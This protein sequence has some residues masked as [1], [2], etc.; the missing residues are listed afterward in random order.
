WKFK[1][2]IQKCVD[3]GDSCSLFETLRSQTKD[4]LRTDDAIFLLTKKADILNG[5]TE[6]YSLLFS[7]KTIVSEESLTAT[8][9][10]TVTIK[11]D[12]YS[13]VVE[14]ETAI[15]KL[16]R[17]IAPGSDGLPEDVYT[18]GTARME[19]LPALFTWC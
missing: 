8:P 16:K 10:E 11:L 14:L 2:N 1:K 13:S 19:R 6:C 18:G 12:K 15:G 5:W 7:N 3:D 9:K 17:H 4:P